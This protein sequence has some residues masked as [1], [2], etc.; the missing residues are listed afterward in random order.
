M[1][2]M[3]VG[4]GDDQDI[5]QYHTGFGDFKGQLYSKLG[6]EAGGAAAEDVMGAPKDSQVLERVLREEWFFDNLSSRG[7]HCD[8]LEIPF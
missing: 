8:F 3:P 4:Y 5:D 1:R 6:V 2:F 7:Y